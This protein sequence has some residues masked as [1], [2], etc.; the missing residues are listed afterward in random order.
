MQHNLTSCVVLV[1]NTVRIT[2]TERTDKTIVGRVYLQ[3]LLEVEGK[4]PVIIKGDTIQFSK[5]NKLTE[6]TQFETEFS[7]ELPRRFDLV[8]PSPPNKVV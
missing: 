8:P 5:E 6:K 7:Y 1:V 4:R 2:S 3:V